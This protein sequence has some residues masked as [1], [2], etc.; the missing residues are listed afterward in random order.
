MTSILRQREII[1]RRALAAAMDAALD[2]RSGSLPY[3]RVLLPA[4]RAALTAGHDEI[5]R[6][7]GDDAIVP[8][9][10]RDESGI[11]VKRRGDQQ[12]GPGGS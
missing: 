10:L 11:R 6:R 7:F 1:D 4:L 5:R 9:A 8:A 3:R 2:E 12:W